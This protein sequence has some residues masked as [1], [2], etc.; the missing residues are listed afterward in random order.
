MVGITHF[1]PYDLWQELITRSVQLSHQAYVTTF[2]ALTHFF[3]S[4]TVKEPSSETLLRLA[5]LVLTLN[6]FS[7]ADHYYKQINGVA[8]GTKMGPSYANLSV[9]YIEHQFFNQY[10]GPK[11]ELYRRYIDDCIGATSSTREDLNQFITAVNSFHPALKYTWEISDT[12]L[13]FLDIKVSIEGNALCTSVHY[14]PTDSHG[15]L[16]YSSSHPSH[17]KNSIPYSQF[18][19]LRRLCSD[20]SEFSLKSEEMCDFFDKRGYPSVVRAGHHRAQQ[21]DRQS[22]LQTS[23][24]ENNDRIPFTLTFHPQNHAVK[25]I[26]LR[27]FKLL[28]NDPDTV[29]IFSQPP[30]ISFKRDKNIGNFLVRSAF[31]TSDQPGTFKCSRARWKTCPFI[32]NV[33]KISGPKR[34]I[35]IT[36]H[37]TCTSANVIYCITCTLCKKLYIGETGR[38]LGDRF[39]EHPR[40][41]E[42]DENNASKPIAIR[43][44]LPNHSKQH[45]AV[46][47]L[48]L[49]QGSTESRKTLEQKFIFLIGSLNPHGIN[50]HFSF[51]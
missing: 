51:N 3:D 34:S 49:H 24:K 50:E 39:R 1:C 43:V 25:S 41:V 33:G 11:P 8:M 17:V 27:N 23:Q 38:R 21:I 31:Q 22:S 4:R 2:L 44:N 37:F 28:Q 40:D 5:E 46:C 29:S 13:A 26:I 7:F 20:D 36:D 6:C 14:K 10:N 15:Y 18:L 32:H 48:S 19:R 16:L 45:M 42:K 12:S 35:T 47:G 30:L 9:G